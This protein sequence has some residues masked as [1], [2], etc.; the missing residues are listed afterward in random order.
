MPSSASRRMFP[1]SRMGMGKRF[2]IPRLR[3]IIAIRLMTSTGPSCTAWP[4]ST[5]MPTKLCNCRTESFPEKSLPNIPNNL[6]VASAV[7]SEAS[8]TDTVSVILLKTHCVP[9]ENQG[10]A[11]QTAATCR[12]SSDHLSDKGRRGG[13]PE[14]LI[15]AAEV[16]RLHLNGFFRSLMINAEAQGALGRDLLK[17]RTYLGPVW[18]RGIVNRNQ[19]VSVTHAGSC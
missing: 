14:R 7:S 17:N 3:L 15:H 18:R 16:R 4:A 12:H 13:I 5:A 9:G 8:L 2:K 1:P 10:A 19:M 11:L 6:R